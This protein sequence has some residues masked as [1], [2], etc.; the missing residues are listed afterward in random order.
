[1]NET[2]LK[3]KVIKMLRK[4]FPDVWF[5]K[6]HDMFRSGLPDLILCVHGRFCAIELKVGDNG[7]TKLQE[8]EIGKIVEACGY[9][10]VCWS[11]EEARRVVKQISLDIK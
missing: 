1:M 7:P 9:A 6:V 11:V 10:R 8:Y 5:F 2:Q 4:E 3:I